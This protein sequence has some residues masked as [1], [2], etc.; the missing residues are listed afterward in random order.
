M[1]MKR[2]AIALTAAA[3]GLAI[4]AA[5][6]ARPDGVRAVHGASGGQA[7]SCAKSVQIGMLA[8]ITGPAASIGDD[9][10]H[11]AQFY[12]QQWNAK[13]RLKIKL[14]QGDT[15]LDPSKA[16]VVAQQFASNGSMVAVIG[17]AGSQEVIASSPILKKAGLAFVSGSATRVSLTDG[18]LRGFFF[19]VVPN[20]GVQGPTDADYMMSNHG[21]K[22]NSE[23]MVV[24]DKEAYS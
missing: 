11:W 14:V 21:V 6:Y 15:Q 20:D 8:P 12:V 7:I 17:P 22:K 4:V 3:V 16:S 24:D 1:S 18:S 10:L 2:G 23:V 5:A 9:Q 13:H 19:R